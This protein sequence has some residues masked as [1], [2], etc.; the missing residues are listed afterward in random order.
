MK[1]KYD[2]AIKLISRYVES[3]DPSI[4]ESRHL[5]FHNYMRVPAEYG[6]LNDPGALVE[7][8]EWRNHTSHVYDKDVAEDLYAVLPTTAE[9]L[10][11]AC[12]QLEKR[13]HA[14]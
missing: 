6:L 1:I 11:H 10:C 12:K 4:E 9:T 2:V 14:S 8:R 13:N 3:G 5:N 7:F